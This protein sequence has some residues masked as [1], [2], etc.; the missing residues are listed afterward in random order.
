M[1]YVIFPIANDVAK[2]L[3]PIK[4]TDYLKIEAKIEAIINAE[5]DLCSTYSFHNENS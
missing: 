1:Y 3:G 2:V 4:H 5:R